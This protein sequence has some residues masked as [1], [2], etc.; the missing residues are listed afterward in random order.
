VSE[1]AEGLAQRIA[2]GDRR[3]LAR[4]ITLV[5]SERDDHALRAEHLLEQLLPA[6]GRAIRIGVSGPPGV[7]KSTFIEAL[8]RHAIGCGHR[9]A[10]LAVD[11]SSRRSGGAILADKTRMP[12]LA[13]APEAFVRPSPAGATLGGVARR[14]REAALFCEAAGFDV[15]LIETVGVGQSETAVAGMVD[16]FLLLLAPGGGDLLQGIKRGIVE[17]ADLVVVT[18]ADGDLAAAARRI[19]ADYAAALRLLRPRS[20]AWTP[21]VLTCSALE[22]KGIE[23][24]WQTVLAHRRAL[25]DADGLA[26]L[27]ACQARGWLWQ[28]IEAGLA[29]EL[30]QDAATAALIAELER[31]VG[32]GRCLPPAAARRI[33]SRF[34]DRT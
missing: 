29:R 20:G 4:G 9:L 25:E 10:V 2:Q 3:A 6:T 5:E 8:G 24:V 14:T 27:R 7:G 11:P 16:S 12:A 21:R 1:P 30:R 13:R 18:K 32:A 33:V 15:V 22:G 28:E 26:S 23:K 19:A 17:F 31:A 34:R